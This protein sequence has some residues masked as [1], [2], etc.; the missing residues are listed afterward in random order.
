MKDLC[1]PRSN[2]YPNVLR[3]FRL[4]IYLVTDNDASVR[5]RCGQCQE[6]VSRGGR[7]QHAMPGSRLAGGGGAA[8][9][10]RQPF[11]GWGRHW[12]CRQSASRLKHWGGLRAQLPPGARAC[13]A[14]QTA[15]RLPELPSQVHGTHARPSPTAYPHYVQLQYLNATLHE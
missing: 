13:P 7:E 5:W 15:H 4:A 14:R 9:N 2:I 10:A 6:A 11:R 8:D 3:P 12:L 1:V